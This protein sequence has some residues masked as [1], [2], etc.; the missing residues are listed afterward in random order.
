MRDG[1][2]KTLGPLLPLVV[3]LGL[4]WGRASH[5]QIAAPL[6]SVV[7]FVNVNVIATDRER[8]LAGQTVIVRDGRIAKVGPA[9][10]VSPPKGGHD[11][12]RRTG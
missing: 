9:K 8:V 2:R 7:A 4:A 5:Q 1:M 6:S 10:S 12:C 11:H 3:I